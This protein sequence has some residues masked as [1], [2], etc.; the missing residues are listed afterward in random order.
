MNTLLYMQLAKF[1]Y[2]RLFAFTNQTRTFCYEQPT[3]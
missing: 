3:N 1:T 2:M